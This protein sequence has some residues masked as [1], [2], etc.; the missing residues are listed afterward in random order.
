MEAAFKILHS[1]ILTSGKNSHLS[2]K[3]QGKVGEF[4]CASPVAT[5]SQ[6]CPENHLMIDISYYMYIHRAHMHG[7]N[8]KGSRVVGNVDNLMGYTSLVRTCQLLIFIHVH[9]KDMNNL[10]PGLIK[11]T[12]FVLNMLSALIF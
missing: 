1:L 7:E 10:K 12:K 3:C 9:C 6:G 11:M 2:G 5:L 4:L 8:K